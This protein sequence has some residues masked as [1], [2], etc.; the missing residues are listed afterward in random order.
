MVDW[1]ASQIDIGDY[2]EFLETY[3]TEHGIT[4]KKMWYGVTSKDIKNASGNFV[5]AK[6]GTLENALKV[7]N[8]C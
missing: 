6:F 7:W 8:H 5:I 2:R 3:E 1:E 4:D